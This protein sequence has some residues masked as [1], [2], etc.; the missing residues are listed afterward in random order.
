VEGQAVQA[1]QFSHVANT[2]GCEAPFINPMQLKDG[3]YW[4]CRR[5]MDGS[6]ASFGSFFRPSDQR[7]NRDTL[8]TLFNALMA[9]ILT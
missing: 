3:F 7:A 1:R 9:N 8:G 4:R 2:G 6:A 5:E